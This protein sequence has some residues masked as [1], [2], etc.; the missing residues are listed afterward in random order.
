MAESGLSAGREGLVRPTPGL[1]ERVGELTLATLD[2]GDPFG[3]LGPQPGELLL[4]SNPNGVQP[5]SSI[6]EIRR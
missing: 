6:D 2:G 1:R 5:P 3:Q 4:S